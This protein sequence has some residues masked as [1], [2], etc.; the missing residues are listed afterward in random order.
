MVVAING[1]WKLPIGYFFISRLQCEEKARLVEFAL[2]KLHDV[3]IQAQNVTCDCPAVNWATFK[4]LGA[5]FEPDNLKPF[6]PH[7][8]NPS[9]LVQ[10]VL[11]PSHLIKLV[12]NSLS[13]L[14]TIC[15]AEGNQIK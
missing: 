11:D 5:G 1:S 15:D 6:F 12:R 13:D 8:C 10:V 7:P 3:G 14:G 2:K 4:W 9:Q